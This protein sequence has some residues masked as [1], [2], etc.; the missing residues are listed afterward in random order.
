MCTPPGLGLRQFSL[1]LIRPCCQS[2]GLAFSTSTDFSWHA[3]VPAP[4]RVKVSQR[5]K[6]FPSVLPYYPGKGELASAA[7]IM[8]P[9]LYRLSY[10]AISIDRDRIPYLSRAGRLESYQY[11][12]GWSCRT[13]SSSC[14]TGWLLTKSQSRPSWY[15][16]RRLLPLAVCVTKTGV[17]P[18]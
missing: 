14:A 16:S 17:F 6:H 15:H 10:A 9:L 2:C 12:I 13:I 3:C 1:D 5:F 8:S 4:F 18:A 11:V 7:Q